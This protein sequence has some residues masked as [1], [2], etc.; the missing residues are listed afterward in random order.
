MKEEKIRQFARRVQQW[1]EKTPPHSTVIPMVMSRI[2]FGHEGQM[3][4][5][6]FHLR[7]YILPM[8][9]GQIFAMCVIAFTLWHMAVQPTVVLPSMNAA[10]EIRQIKLL[11]EAKGNCSDASCVR[12]YLSERHS[13]SEKQLI[14]S[15]LSQKI[16]KE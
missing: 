14:Q 8:M 12:A 2:A 5:W 7:R 16:W 6:P 1:E 4:R 15:Y 10:A 9:C 3:Q 11:K 13:L